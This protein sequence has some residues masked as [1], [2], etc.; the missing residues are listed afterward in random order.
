MEPIKVFKLSKYIFRFLPKIWSPISFD[1]WIV[2][3]V[4]L[5][6]LPICKLFGHISS[7]L[8][9]NPLDPNNFDLKF[10][11]NFFSIIKSL[12]KTNRFAE[13]V[14]PNDNGISWFDYPMNMNN[15]ESVTILKQIAPMQKS[16][17]RTS[18][19]CFSV[20]F[21]N[22][23]LLFFVLI[24]ES[25]MLNL[26]CDFLFYHCI[27]DISHGFQFQLLICGPPFE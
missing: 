6:P 13:H 20:F 27:I 5:M 25:I 3:F 9:K 4:C 16:V 2:T 22:V 15:D 7:P 10:C 19:L 14:N 12:E 24:K 26:L 8:W 17:T 11:S 23:K 18:G 21:F 1:F